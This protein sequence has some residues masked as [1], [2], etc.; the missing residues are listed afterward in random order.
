MRRPWLILGAVIILLLATLAGARAYMSYK[1]SAAVT[2]QPMAWAATP[3]L[4]RP[5]LP[6]RKTAVSP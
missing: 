4:R 3:F 2:V 5:L 6:V 1:Q